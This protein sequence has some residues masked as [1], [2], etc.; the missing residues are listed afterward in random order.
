VGCSND[1]SNE[2]LSEYRFEPISFERLETL[3]ISIEPI[4]QTYGVSFK[5]APLQG[6][7]N[8]GRQVVRPITQQ[9]ST[10]H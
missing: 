7:Q 3:A 5:T 6:L 1:V 9:I 10:S 2:V 4:P 8:L